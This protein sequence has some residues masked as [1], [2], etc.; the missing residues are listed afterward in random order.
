MLKA[1]F[2]VHD[3]R[4]GSCT[5]GAYNQGGISPFNQYEMPNIQ[6]ITQTINSGAKVIAYVSLRTEDVDL[7]LFK[8]PA[9]YNKAEATIISTSGALINLTSGSLKIVHTPSIDAATNNKTAITLND[10][11]AA[12]LGSLKMSIDVAIATVDVD[13][14]TVYFPIPYN[15]DITI[16]NKATLTIPNKVKLLSGA[17]ITVEAGGTLDLTGGGMIVYDA[18]WAD[19]WN[20]TKTGTRVYPTGKGAAQIIV[21]GTFNVG[22]AFGGAIKGEASGKVV[23]K[24]TS[25]SIAA[26]EGFGTRSGLT[27]SFTQ[28]YSQTYNA[29]LIGYSGSLS[30]G[31]TYT[32]NGSSWTKS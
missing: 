3:F 23:V 16:N 32:F 25:L 10:E 17:K 12:E 15:F 27:F 11:S 22:A 9:S 6:N 18:N 28:T 31:S 5:G 29:S 4:G 7:K 26:K 8:L 14:S 13:T 21:R 1:P 24:T 20:G 2:V 19:D 30:N